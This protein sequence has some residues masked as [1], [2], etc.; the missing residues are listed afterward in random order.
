MSMIELPMLLGVIL[1]VRPP[2]RLS[3]FLLVR[4]LVGYFG[5]IISAAKGF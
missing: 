3:D 1:E 5:Y 4:I 2:E